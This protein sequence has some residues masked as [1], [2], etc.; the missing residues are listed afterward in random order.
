MEKK[1]EMGWESTIEEAHI[2]PD[3]DAKGEKIVYDFEVIQFKRNPQEKFKKE[4]PEEYSAFSVDIKMNLSATVNEE[5]IEGAAEDKLILTLKMQFKIFQYFTAID[6]REKG[7]G[8]FD[9]VKTKAWEPKTNVGAVGKCTIRHDVFN[10]QTRVKI[11]RY[12]E[13]EDSGFNV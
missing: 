8:S 12:L 2:I 9:P 5:K 1:P 10:G 7:S 3:K 4:T 6:L 11:D 13:P